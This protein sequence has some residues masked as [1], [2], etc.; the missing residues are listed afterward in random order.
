M[1][2]VL[3]LL[4]S[5]KLLKL[6]NSI[7]P[8]SFRLDFSTNMLHASH[9]FCLFTLWSLY[10]RISHVCQRDRKILRDELNFT[11]YTTKTQ[12][13]LTTPSGRTVNSTQIISQMWS[14]S[15]HHG[16]FLPRFL[17]SSRTLIR[18]ILNAS[19][20]LLRTRSWGGSIVQCIVF[21][22]RNFHA[23]GWEGGTKATATA[24]FLVQ[25]LQS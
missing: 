8:Q 23:V 4:A 9:L 11:N 24:L 20:N 7:K 22:Q 19:N 1:Q 15:L 13:H 2:G 10:L 16:S 25:F 6:V 14:V 3:C 21:G 17:T 12:P 18:N 5:K